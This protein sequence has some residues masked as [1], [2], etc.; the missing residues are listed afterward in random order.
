[1]STRGRIAIVIAVIGVVV[2]GQT[3]ADAWPRETPIIYEVGPDVGE[4]DVDF[5][6]N[7]E[8]IHSVR[9][10]RAYRSSQTLAHTPRLAPGRYQLHVTVRVQD[11]GAAEVV[12]ALVVPTGT[13]GPTRID[14]RALTP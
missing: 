1:M 3:L 4:L 9:F 11:S 10:R 12:R 7:G 13:E 6:Q 2:V 5:L 8:A 14:L